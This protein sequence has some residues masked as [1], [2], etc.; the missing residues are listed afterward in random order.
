MALRTPDAP[1]TPDSTTEAGVIK[2]AR[3]RQRRHR[4]AWML[5]TVAALLAGLIFAFSGGGRGSDGADNIH[6]V[7]LNADGIRRLSRR[8]R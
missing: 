4:I 8:T 1:P 2:D 5:P 6:G 3:Q 7:G